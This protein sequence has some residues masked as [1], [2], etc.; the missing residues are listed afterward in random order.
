MKGNMRKFVAISVVCLVTAP[1]LAQDRLGIND[2]AAILKRV[3]AA[4]LPEKA[5]S[6]VKS[7]GKLERETMA[8]NVVK[9]AVRIGPA[10]APLI[11]G[12]VA[13]AVPEVAAS[14]AQAAALEQ[15]TQAEDV[16]RAAA[17]V[18]SARAGEIVLAVCHAAPGQYKQIAIAVACVAPT[19]AR[20]ILQA[21]C[22]FRPEL[23]LYIDVEIAMR[24]L[25]TPSVAWCL[26]QAEAAAAANR[27]GSAPA[28]EYGESPDASKSK[29]P[30]HGNGNPPGGRNYARP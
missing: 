16:A 11:V 1:L 19:E 5:A 13:R 30:P 22:A 23:K 18:A 2:V 25:E 20:N 21:V 26:A 12:A 4:E 29:P 9:I 14:S 28:R 8:T 7:F 6:L 24:P 10:A 27:T 17:A 3:P 15:P